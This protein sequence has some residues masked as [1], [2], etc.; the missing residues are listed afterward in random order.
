MIFAAGCRT[1]TWTL[2]YKHR[3]LNSHP[4]KALLSAAINTDLAAFD[5]AEAAA[6]EALR[7]R[8]NMVDDDGFTMVVRGA[9][10]REATE[11]ELLEAERAKKKRK[12]EN[13]TA[14]YRF[15]IRESRKEAAKKLV[16]RFE[17]DKRR[18]EERKAKRRLRPL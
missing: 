2:G 10:P 16:E 1:D 15:Q 11:A 9:R 5:Q 17:E 3:F 12:S 13:T 6:A 8:A 7:A 14:F 4:D 18:L